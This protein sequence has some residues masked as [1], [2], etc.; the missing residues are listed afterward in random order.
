MSTHGCHYSGPAV[1]YEPPRLTG[2][3]PPSF[4]G[5]PPLPPSYTSGEPGSTCSG[6]GT[7]QPATHRPHRLMKASS[8]SFSDQL[9]N[10]TSREPGST[11][12]GD[13]IPYWDYSDEAQRPLLS[14]SPSQSDV[15]VRAARLRIILVI[16]TLWPIAYF[17][18]SVVFVPSQ[19]ALYKN[20][21]DDAQA[22]VGHLLNEKA[23][24]VN[25][26]DGLKEQLNR[27]KVEAFWEI[28]RTMDTNMYVSVLSV[29][30]HHLTLLLR[31]VWVGADD[32]GAGPKFWSY[33]ITNGKYHNDDPPVTATQFRFSSGEAI[34][35]ESTDRR[36]V[37]GYRVQSNRSNNGW[38]MATGLNE[39]GQS[40]DH[41]LQFVARGG[42][43]HNGA[44]YG[45]VVFYAERA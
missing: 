37:V 19:V 20:L 45:V 21:Y 39:F 41:R 16:V 17:I 28:A 6:D 23:A 30:R 12:S 43:P 29:S 7:T 25:E 38:W 3:S 22:Q 44:E 5:L 42:P 31:D 34:V 36:R 27:A 18:Y 40:G 10:Y 4:S 9:P 13:S 8:P 33:G 35:I 2:P 15:S 14:S 11:Y 26:V 24:L 1:I 32:M